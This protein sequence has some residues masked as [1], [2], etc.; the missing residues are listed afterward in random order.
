M[1]LAMAMPALIGALALVYDVQLLYF[2]WQLLQKA[3]DSAA[4]AGVSYL[5][6][7]PSIAISTADSYAESNGIAA[8]EIVS[9]TI[10]SD[11][12]SLSIRLRR[13]VPYNFA[14]AL[15]LAD[16]LVSAK[17]RARIESTG[18][19]TDIIPIGINYLTSYTSG[20]VVNLS[21]GVGPGNWSA[22]AMGASGSSQWETN[23]ENGYPGTVSVGGLV[24]TQTG[25][26]AGPTKTAFEYLLNQGENVDPSGT[27][28]SHTLNDP[29]VLLVPMVDFSAVNGNSQVPVKGFAALWLFS[30][31]NKNDISA[32]FINQV[33][34]NGAPD[35]NASNFGAYTAILTE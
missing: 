28:S 26:M 7:S 24:T 3:A 10:S 4:V 15:G 1:V 21:Q 30:V 13:F 11:D 20:Q 16:G 29:R 25:I 5:P 34:P 32:Y 17:A 2:N 27:F 12:T 9:T 35:S 14:V 6:Q 23:V 31:N 19:G 8:S 22:L 33:M 18:S